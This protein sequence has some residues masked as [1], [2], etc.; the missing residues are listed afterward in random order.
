MTALKQWFVIINPTSGN[1]LG[2]R[3]WPIIKEKLLL[4]KFIFNFAFTKY[5]NHSIEL[6]QKAINEGFKNIISVG[7]DGTLHNIINGILRQKTISS[8][9]IKIGVIPIGTGNDW[10]KTHR[11]PM[12]ISTAISVIKQGHVKYQ[13]LG[14][15]KFINNSLQAIYFNNLAGIGFDGHVVSKVSKYKHFG[16]SAYL[17]AALAELCSFKNFKTCISFDGKEIKTNAFMI[18]IG[19]C[20]FS[21]GGMRLTKNPNSGDGLF[22]LSIAKN[23]TKL[24]VIKNLP[25]LFN[26]RIVNHAKVETYKTESIIIKI[27]SQQYP[28]IEA[29][30]ELI[31]KG[32][33]EVSILPQSMSFYAPIN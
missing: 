11:I 13:D 22:D 32:H 19:L 4:E 18:L 31:G 27:A 6:V 26:G 24:D 12:N 16:A 33:I 5:Q 17:V 1:G 21:G 29:D 25:N 3:K 23:F 9:N 28:F 2:G 20:R 8:S 15:L 7:G 10:V 30:G 14:K